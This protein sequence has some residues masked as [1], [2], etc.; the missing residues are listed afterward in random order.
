MFDGLMSRWTTPASCAAASALA[1]WRPTS[2][3]SR[4]DS[5]ERR[6]R[7]ARSSPSSHSIA[8][9]VVPS[10]MRR[11]SASVVVESS[12]PNATTRTIPG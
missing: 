4:S 5:G 8:M 7:D 6:W 10:S 3:P 1:T 2:S 9:N 11:P 12:V